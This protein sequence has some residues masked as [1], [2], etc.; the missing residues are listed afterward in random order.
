MRRGG[1]RGSESSLLFGGGPVVRD[2]GSE[3]LPGLLERDPDEQLDD[4]GH[5]ELVEQRVDLGVGDRGVVARTASAN[6]TASD[7]LR[8]S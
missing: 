6:A 7:S 3:H 8:V 4:L 2:E 5:G 1:D